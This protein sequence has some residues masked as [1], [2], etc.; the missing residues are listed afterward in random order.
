MAI[1]AKVHTFLRALLKEQGEPTWPHHLT[2][3]RLVARALR[4][5]RPVLIQTATTV[6]RYY[7]SYLTP[8]LLSPEPAI[9]VAPEVV[10]KKL[11]Q[12]EIPRLQEWLQTNKE[13]RTDAIG[14]SED[15][16]RG[17]ML[18][19]PE[20][21]LRDRLEGK[22][23]IPS[24][25]PTI[26]DR[27]DNLEEW[28]RSQLTATIEPKDWEESM[29]KFP[30]LAESI[31]N[32]RVKLSK[33]IF[34][35]PKNPYECCL[36]PQ[37]EQEILKHLCQT[38]AKKQMLGEAF[39]KFWHRWQTDGEIISASIARETQQFT[40]NIG[41]GTV[42]TA[43][44]KIWQQQPVVLIGS[45]LDREK[46]AEIYRQ[47]LGIPEILCLKFSPN[48]QS[49]YLKLYLP[50]RLPMPNTPE[51]KGVL[52]EQLCTT[53]TLCS[54]VEKPVVV[55]VEDVPLKAQTGAMLAAE[56]GSRVRVEKTDLAKNGILIS[57]WQFWH[58]N[59]EVL[60]T[61]HLLAIATL[62]FPS[63]EN[64]LVAGRVAYYK[65]QR[66]DWFRLYLLPTGLREIQR[67]VVPLREDR[68]I[69]ALFDNRVNHRSYGNI[70]LSA[71]EPCARINYLDRSWFDSE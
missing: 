34:D 27:A 17:I 18:V 50:E 70:I 67:A 22:G 39:A 3:A 5:G 68:G 30:L 11:L 6:E 56:F 26:I 57:G 14:D 37:P 59:Q 48:R 43:C 1:E 10:Q 44:S 60:P 29:E 64:P 33:A 61:P 62:P 41:P 36:I 52:L 35:R 23:A 40:L 71:L 45:F 15:N 49:E 2:M 54:H 25:I 53:V 58:Q 24:N 19:S 63:L 69:V 32:V 12:K 38:L 31:D 51:F 55:L 9:V 65:R 4:L 21:W 16:F 42:S 8:A 47:E 13:I 20:V 7:L 46:N 28:A 66:Q